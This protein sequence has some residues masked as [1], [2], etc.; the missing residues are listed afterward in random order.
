MDNKEK[1]YK[2]LSE[3]Y[4]LGTFEQFSA[5]L[6][7]EEKRRKL[8]DATS[9]DYDYGDYESFSAQLGYKEPFKMAEPFD[10]N[11]ANEESLA[12]LTAPQQQAYVP[13]PST[14]S[15]Y[16]GQAPVIE[17]APRR[18]FIAG[19]QESWKGLKAGTQF[20]YG[21]VVN[22]IFG[23]SQDDANALYE[24]NEML[25]QGKDVASEVE[26]A[27]TDA[28]RE[29]RTGALEFLPGWAIK[30]LKD[31][32]YKEAEHQKIL[33]DIREVLGET[34]GDV[35]KARQILE[36]RA[37]DLSHGDRVKL[38]A[39][40]QFGNIRE[41]EGFGAW[42]GENT[43][44]MI[45]SASALIVG[46]L[47]K[48]PAAARA[49]GMIGMGGMTAA[50][51][52]SSMYEAREAGASDLET[53]KVGVVD[54]AIEYITEKLPFDN[55]TNWMV[56][57]TKGKVATEVARA[58]RSK[59]SPV[60]AEMEKL[61][62]MANKELGGKLFSK[63][64]A[65]A[66]IAD[67]VAEGASEFTAEASQT[68][69]RLMY[70][71]PD[72]F[73]LLGE[74]LAN[75]WQG[76]LAGF[77]MGGV[78]GGASKTMEHHQNRERRQ[79][80]GYVDVGLVNF[81]TA[82][83]P[84][85]DIVEVISVSEDTDLAQVL[86]DGAI[87]NVNKNA[88][89]Q[90]YRYSYE[91]F[92]AGRMRVLESEALDNESVTQ[93]MIQAADSRE[94]TAQQNL[95]EALRASGMA[96]DEIMT[97]LDD[98]DADKI[99]MFDSPDIENAYN[100]YRDARH[101][102][103]ELR[104][105][106]ARQA[107]SALNLKRL[108]I[109]ENAGQFW[110]DNQTEDAN[111]NPIFNPT[112][113]TG[114]M[115]DGTRVYVL[116]DVNEQGECAA[117]TENGEKKI[118]KAD[119]LQDGTQVFTLDEYLQSLVDADK[120]QQEQTRMV[121]Q[122]QDR[123]TQARQAA[124]PGTQINLGTEEDPVI[125]SVVEQGPDGVIVQSE[126]GASQLT[127]DEYANA[128]HIGAPALTDNETAGVEAA[129]ILSAESAYNNEV[130][131]TESEAKEVADESGAALQEF[132]QADPLPRDAEGNVD[133]T[134]LWNDSPA[135][136]AEWNDEQ[137][138]DGGANSIQ[139]IDAAVAK[140][141]AT[142]A[143]QQAAYGA[144]PVG[145]ERNAVE[146]EIASLQ[147]RLAELLNVQQRY[148]APVAEEVTETAAEAP[149]AEVVEEPA[150]EA[151][152][153]VRE[154][155]TQLYN[156]PELSE[157]E[158][159]AFINAN[160]QE[161]QKALDKHLDKA[162]KMGTDMAKYKADRAK[163][164][165]KTAELE[166]QR[167]FWR[168][169]QSYIEMPDVTEMDMEPQNALEFTANELTR[170]DGV[171]LQR[172][173]FTR[174]TGYGS[175]AGN[176]LSMLRTKQNGGLTLEEAGERLMEMDREN[177]TGFF[178][179]SDPNAGL[180]AI[181]EV[182]GGARTSGDVSGYIKAN[183]EQLAREEMAAARNAMMEEM[184]QPEVEIIDNLE[185]DLPEDIFMR[186]VDE[187]EAIGGAATVKGRAE[188][189]E[190]RLGIKMNVLED[191]SQVKNRAI[192]KAIER[193][194]QA[195]GWFDRATGEVCI[196]APQI[197]NM[198]EVDKTVI[199]E[200][201]SHKGLR[202]LLGEEGFNALCDYVWQ[203]MKPEARAKYLTYE[204]VLKGERKAEY[205][206]NPEAFIPT[207]K[208]SRAAAD[209]FI[210]GYSESI[211]TD[212][213]A[214][215]K[216][217][218]SVKRFINKLTGNYSL[219]D[220]LDELLDA[221]LARYETIAK[222]DLQGVVEEGQ[223]YGGI[224][225][226]ETG[227]KIDA[228][229]DIQAEGN[230]SFRAKDGSLVGMHNISE[231]KL[232]K[233]IKQGGLANPSTAVVNID[234]YSLEG[235][236]EIS[237]IMPSSLV[238]P[239]TGNNAGTYSGDAWTPTYPSISR[240]VDD[241]GWKVIKDRI[242][243]AVGEE[244]ALYSDI[245][246]GVD[247]YLDDN[248]RSKM[249]FVF[250][251]EKGIEPE[252]KYKGAEGLVG[253]RNL[254]AIL[255]V[256]GLR[257]GWESYEKY[258]AASPMS[259]R[260]FNMWV[261]SG[262]DKTAHRELK[263]MLKKEPR[264]A[265][266]L[267]L[268]E[269]LPFAKFDSFTYHI[270]KTERDAGR[271]DTY[272]TM[273][274]A[275]SYVDANNLRAEFEQWL[276]SLM[277][278]A[279]AREVFF[280]GF[281]RDG[282]RIYKDNTLENVSR[283]M[284]MQ[285][286]TN[287]YDDKGLSAT[288]SVLLERFESLSQIRRNRGRLADERT[289]NKA[290]DELKDRLYNIIS[291]LSDMETISS[292]PF[293]NLDY[294]ESRLQDALTKRNPVAYLNKEYGYS[295]DPKG[296][297]ASE[298]KSFI[299][300][301]QKMPAKYFETKFE[302]PVYLN[303][304]AAAVMPA[305]TG[306]DIKQAISEAGLPIYEYDSS[307]EGA[308]HEATLKA[309]DDND[310]RFRII[311]EEG[312][313]NLDAA[314][315]A[316]VRLDNLTA[317]REMEA[318]GKDAKAIKL[319]T[320]WERGT[321]N[322]WR[323]EVPDDFDLT[324]L[325]NR[326]QE[327]LNDGMSKAWGIVYPS[328]LGDLVNE[329]PDFNVDI[330]VWVGDE[331]DNTGEYS[332]AT[333]G[334]E[335][336]FG[337]SASIEVRAKTVA[338]IKS[339]LV[340]EIQ[341]AIQEKEGFAEGGN[342]FG[343][344]D[345][346]SAELDKRVERIK[347]LRAEGRDAEADEL[348]SMSKGL[349]EAV[350]NN[351]DDA[352]GNYRK[353]A[354]E[355]EARNASARLGMTMQERR[356]TLLSETEDVAPEDQ[357]ILMDAV[358]SAGSSLRFRISNENQ[359]IFVS[360][361][362]RAVEGIKQEKATPE[363]WLKMIEKNGGLK[364]GE[365]KWMGL[366]D[367]LKASDKK[368]L[369]K[370]E[371]LDFIN[372]NMI[373]IEEQH[374]SE[375]EN[376]L[377]G[378][379]PEIQE[380][381]Q[382]FFDEYVAES[383]DMNDDMF[384]KTHYDYAIQKLADK[385][386][387]TAFNAPFI[388]N[389]ALVELD[390]Y[391]D[392]LDTLH[393]LNNKLGLEKYDGTRDI[394]DT[395][396]SYTTEGLTD[397]HEIA[398]VVPT[399]ESWNES[400]DIHFGDAGDG[401]A[402]AW[403]RFGDAMKLLGTTEVD[404]KKKFNWAKVLVID[405]IQSK[406]HQEGRE[407]GYRTK[408]DDEL[409]QKRGVAHW[410]MMKKYNVST[411]Y[412]L[413]QVIS[414]EDAQ[415]LESL[416]Q[417][418]KVGEIPDAPFDK[419]WHEL[420][421][422]RMLRYAAENGYDVIAWTKG[423]QQADRYNIG[424]IISEIKSTKYPRGYEVVS[425]GNNG[426]I[427]HNEV[428][429]DESA[430]AGVYG[431]E[432]AKRIIESVDALE[433]SETATISGD[434]LRIGGEGMKGFYDKMLPA[435]MNKY[436]KKWGVKVEDINLPGLANGLTMH[437]VP[438]TEEMKA[439]VM[440]GQVM[441]RVRGENE[442]AMDFHQS[443]VDDFLAKYNPNTEVRVFPVNEETARMFG[444]TLEELKK[445]HGR[446]LPS[447]DFI[448]IFAREDIVEG[449]DVEGTLFH[450]SIHKL[451]QF[452]DYMREAGK[453]MYENSDNNEV[454]AEY[455]KEIIDKNYA[456]YSDEKKHEE[457]LAHALEGAMKYGGT[458]WLLA[459]VPDD[460]KN[461]I[462]EILNEIGYDR[463]RESTERVRRS[464]GESS[465][466]E[467]GTE[468]L[469]GEK[470]PEAGGQSGIQET[471]R[472]IAEGGTGS[473][474]PQS[475]MAEDIQETV[476][477]RESQSG[478]PRQTGADSGSEDVSF[479]VTDITPEVRAEMNTISAIALVNGTY[480]KA[481]NGADT[482]L[483]PEQWALVRTKNFLRWFGDWIN[484]PENASKV[485]DENGE[486]KV[487]YHGSATSGI[488]AFDKSRIRAGETD[489]NYNGFWFS[490]DEDTLPAWVRKEARYDVFL[491][492]VNPISDKE[493]EIISKEVLLSDKDYAGAR[494]LA[495]A[496]RF[497]LQSRG[498]DGVLH[499]TH[500]DIDF[501]KLENDGYV[502]FETSRGAR[503]L[504]ERNPEGVYEIYRY[505]KYEEDHKGAFYGDFD[506]I[507]DIKKDPYFFGEEIYVVFEPSQIKSA[508]DNTGEF[509]EE[510][511][512]IRYRISSDSET[513][514]ESL[515][516]RT[517]R[518]SGAFSFSGKEKIESRDDVAFIF[519]QLED[520]AIE[521][522]F[523]V[524]VKDGI[525]TVIHVGMG[526][527]SY[528]MIDNSVVLPAYKDFGA[529]KIYM[530]HNHPSGSLYAS[531]ADLD[532]LKT[533]SM[534]I[535]DIS[536]EGIIINTV[537]GEY[538]SFDLSSSTQSPIPTDE[539]IVPVKVLSF[540]KNVFAPDYKSKINERK[541]KG[542]DD[543]ASFLSAHRL[544]EGTK[545]GALLLNRQNMINGNLVTND[546]EVSVENADTLASQI[547]EAANRTGSSA[548]ILFGDFDYSD[549]ALRSLS[550]GIKRA[551]GNSISLLDVV[552][553]EGNHT[554]SLADETLSSRSTLGDGIRFRTSEEAQEL[555]N[556][557]QDNAETLAP[558]QLTEDIWKEEIEGK[559]FS[560]P[561][562]IVRLGHNQFDKNINKGRAREFGMLIPTI[563]RPDLIFEESAPEEGAERQTK[564]VFV[565]TFIDESGAK[566]INYASISV[567]KEGMEVVESSHRLRD[568]QVLNKIEKEQ[569]LWNRFASDS[570][571]SAPGISTDQSN[572]LSDNKDSDNLDKSNDLDENI[573]YRIT[574]TPT[575]QV[576]AEGVSLSP[577]DMARVAGRIFSVLP[578]EA[579]REVTASLNG[580]I[581]GL[582]DAIMQ[583][584]ARL[585][586]KQDWDEQ[587][588]AVAE[589][590]AAEMDRI[591]PDK[592]RPFSTYEGLWMLYDALTPA[593]SLNLMDQAS[594]A[595][596]KRNLGVDEATLERMKGYD[597]DVRFRT[598]GDATINAEASLYNKG[599]S[600]VWT[601]LKE[602]FVDM[603]ASVEKLVKAIEKK[604]GMKAQGFEN[605]LNALNQ[606]SSKGLA[607]MKGYTRTYLKP[608]FKAIREIMDNTDFKYEDIVRYVILKHGLERNRKLA[609]RDAR[610][611][612]QEIY[613]DII[614]KIKG[615]SDA[616]K[617]TYLTN[618]QLRDADAK[619][620]LAGLQNV[621]TSILTD[622]QKREHKR[623]LAKARKAV[624][625]AAEY[626]E[627]AK[628]I[629]SLSEQE[630]Q[631]EL[632]KIFENIEN[633]TDSV[634][635]EL[636]KN[637]YS[638]ISSMFY[639]QLGVNRKDYSTEEQY[640]SALMLAKND[641]Y[642]TLADVEAAAEAEVKTF[643][644]TVSTKELWKRINAATKETLRQQYEANMISRD[645]YES[646]RNMFEY[647]V[648]LRGFKDNTAEDMYTYYR[649]PNSTGYTKPILGAEGRKTEAESPFGWIAAMAGSAVASN[650]KNQAKLA[651]YYFVSNRPENGIATLS[652]T[653]FVDS[654][655]VDADGRKV[656]KP[657][658]PPFTED[659][660]SDAA[661]ASY[662]AWQENMR[663]LQKKGQAY[664]S[665]QRLNL[666]NAV[667]NIS[668]ANK[669]E[670]IVNVKVAGKDYTILINGNPRAAQAINGQLNIEA[671]AQDYTALFGPV[672][673]WMSSVNT[674]YNPEFWITNMMRDMLFT[675]M[676][677]NTK[678]DAAYRRKF[679]KNYLKA[680]KVVKMVHQNEKGT[681][682]DSY[683]EDM[684]KEFEKNGGVTGYTQIKG[685]EEWEKEIAKQ[686][687]SEDPEGKKA[688]K[689]MRK[690]MDGF[691]W[692]HRTGE[693]L[694]QVSRFAAFLT[695]R[696][697]GKPMSE[698]I[699]DAKEIT[700]NFNRKGSGKRITFE[701]ARYLTDKNGQPLNAFQQWLA[702]GL[703]SIAP[704]GRRTIMFFNAAM[705]GL[706]ATAKLIKKNPQ[707]MAAWSL[708]YFAIGVMNAVLHNM[709]D[710]DDDYLDMPEYERRNALMLGGNGVYFKW[711][712]PQEM[713]MI[714]GLGDLAV[715]AILGRNP[716]ESTLAEAV[717][718]VTEVLPINP[719]E[720]WRAFL[721]S[722]AIPFVELGV[723]E[724]YKGDPIYNEQKWLSEG[725][726][727]R[728]AKW[729][730]A[731]KSTGRV[732]IEIAKAL[733]SIT[734]GDEYD[735]GRINLQP[736]KL[737]YL[738][739]SA[740]G[741]TVRTA[742]KFVSSVI[743]AIDPEED[744]AIR[745]VPFLNRVLTLNDERYK[746]VHVNDVFEWYENEV[747]HAIS[748]E[749]KFKRDKQTGK[750]EELKASDEYKWIAVYKKYEKDLKLKKAQLKAAPD[751][752]TRMEL[753]K[754][755]DEIKKRVIK[756]ISAMQ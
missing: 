332:P 352:Y 291:Q 372:E 374:Y 710:D 148:V 574:G 134:T 666:G 159:E 297:Y 305:T 665:G 441:F 571:S 521:N 497:E 565:K 25:R 157:S 413:R 90:Q 405:E 265:D 136:W 663:E 439:S 642:S 418:K 615:L 714:Y 522:S 624:E 479:R 755:Q 690:V 266:V 198:S 337:R 746:N 618:A 329:Y 404:G 573:S 557:M 156:D 500:P 533:I 330:M 227:A 219:V 481:P 216:M 722:V 259:K 664:E 695:A 296:E 731:Y 514:I 704:L 545:V 544:G 317:A 547:A 315:E 673:R 551:S 40:R 319:A 357:I 628:K 471:N 652:R 236:G 287:A 174:H 502:E 444:Y 342:A 542:S 518:T 494:S 523:L 111:G 488:T 530:V 207:E 346:L 8:Y 281:T 508:T 656:F 650:V 12:G 495:D 345:K 613:D 425:F 69:T 340:H 92:E 248:H 349:A 558:R 734:G 543:V 661:K 37:M 34:N 397:K 717:K 491:K 18:G 527:T 442:S 562:G 167:D 271:V 161:S 338:D 598:V 39:Q 406:R 430:M 376:A 456:A 640:Q 129:E 87:I 85:N 127:W 334:D 5:D 454:F 462:N 420:A 541:I 400:D 391:E 72:L 61:L 293:I 706:N 20:A 368:T 445:R 438:V 593:S 432:M 568:K 639:D 484:D 38:D 162:P 616:Q 26:G 475:E 114:L 678:E 468:S 711:A 168:E 116:S 387:Y 415:Y 81:G 549:R 745:Q 298:L 4:D 149:A 103:R 304:F 177:G 361:A 249:E 381:L 749:K 609:Q 744:V 741:G 423:E 31:R 713:R 261:D 505:S 379:R 152:N 238:D 128:M 71:N 412:E 52:G 365:D 213:N 556:F 176:F 427:V 667:V 83:N 537:S 702:V 208:E 538:A 580:N 106:S 564:Y 88:I 476:R 143:E 170:K 138:Q 752:R 21:E 178:D 299:K 294:A 354:G 126:A 118:I 245:V 519:K 612:Y 431:K 653:W 411:P 155:L 375:D 183:R 668:D 137:R 131:Q 712:L 520:S 91:A 123:M 273:A 65:A 22:G 719:T 256:E 13:S 220:Q 70:D 212:K 708:A 555:L 355:V 512:D 572:A 386:G 175:E 600:N 707:K 637:D 447:Y 206:A 66:Y 646:L 231:D 182:I 638:G 440:E 504:I 694:E 263:E 632:D 250:L 351:E 283:H 567:Q 477:G 402:V 608:M 449:E 122:T 698:A 94:A 151:A 493:A 701:E 589:A 60:R 605:I 751:T 233:A 579:R 15:Q 321:D 677:V 28:G 320:G 255:G 80:Q 644:G 480:L 416:Y 194:L 10:M 153:P 192:R 507:E 307:V 601:R 611:H 683:L 2:A 17:Q 150:V 30:G 23:S 738:V 163:H 607:A 396:L 270:W 629:A 517:F 43:V 419:N 47:T 33:D 448:A 110:R 384:M 740:F 29:I 204:G 41:T 292:N 641:R 224:I 429:A 24:L 9:D 104:R 343:L 32:V 697:M 720:G 693:S 285:G 469:T 561:I 336:T 685:S 274:A 489:A 260:S 648:P 422:K 229:S 185:E 222:M 217:I 724:D 687:A 703:S 160:V 96:D 452:F 465:I 57:K 584:P 750:L 532:S 682:G 142:I 482:N 312:A 181:L 173:S 735:A 327:N 367:W 262:G 619:A 133:E 226:A 383:E 436:G 620:E 95:V 247:N 443:M 531:K 366:S 382:G 606:Q 358:E 191:V 252:I 649:K 221:S 622:E 268:N 478:G 576:V 284:R 409:V 726:K 301:V 728:T 107:Q 73:P 202:G 117:V 459:N 344:K 3:E 578:E 651:L 377:D 385:L 700:V 588:M 636:R 147:E 295:I 582:Q 42:L 310:V 428:F 172:D 115:Q 674:S 235:Y 49:I 635:Q 410:E 552:R 597:D 130:A 210:A 97:L 546:N 390:F 132:E 395:R 727:E 680:F 280:A 602:S 16:E 506:T 169:V 535:P 218:D 125:G 634:Y 526:G 82:E 201:I 154:T 614:T 203:N 670:H 499:Q 27:W 324:E 733:N 599:A 86:R 146:Q 671:S 373:I 272:D 253:I 232:R 56:G 243:A 560:S 369:T 617:R 407:K 309:T 196:Y 348:M 585:A 186:T 587:D 457:M 577:A 135:R 654:G 705:Q 64:N 269:D 7:N 570:T 102:A 108:S 120:V 51:S 466:G 392:D 643:E 145:K 339:V 237:L 364:A 264:L 524:F 437:S 688:G 184:I 554:L 300:D 498:Y 141:S 11:K 509:S 511:G 575:E 14:D 257:Y 426:N 433:P 166:K 318:A 165:A 140:L 515:V 434:N 753:T 659:L 279:G 180:N 325:E 490:T 124:Q 586:M 496:T 93:G 311:G 548:V 378:K 112:V 36:E 242:R 675:F 540:D 371:V 78:L 681:I 569:M 501:V 725:E 721:P 63:K 699:D 625:E 360:N 350:I 594:R 435:F 347:E 200:V 322:L 718:I 458:E 333:E 76:A 199:H 716:H 539:G 451:A 393:E 225:D 244:P 655:E 98:A 621:N 205:S 77:F 513:G 101:R 610:A 676:S 686:L 662:E 403:I 267:K 119:M 139:A 331:F 121:E 550:K 487:V 277:E 44:Q 747:L 553:L 631:D 54:G 660:S 709:F 306:E 563:E 595:I 463:E 516:E 754:A 215:Q 446:Y 748:L 460:S 421:M 470:G 370:A 209:E 473:G 483:T 55:Y 68:M 48:S 455:R 414:S 464:A 529:D 723:N 679:A 230:V 251:K 492:L 401:R 362:A 79:K 739:Q 730:S 275:S 581:L 696:E 623:D 164:Q 657:A 503:Y 144:M 158:I 67:M 282:D 380:A 604:T 335:N 566:H 756:E 424:G 647:Y 46:A 99:R 195:P 715:E 630:A 179:Q 467:S 109:E 171:K 474:I 627:R 633:G 626:L 241:R 591:T 100:I 510:D 105:T 450:E 19:A 308:R 485:V 75:G 689:M 187:T 316:S 1:L 189:W 328:D 669:P 314:E 326:L 53:H 732:Y 188:A 359:A 35:A 363:Q 389:N 197:P 240:K 58:L 303:E 590:I 583:I 246:L 190:K 89:G 461:I 736:E 356:E 525:P 394:N 341:H 398:L 59:N 211:N 388:N 276:E 289:Y 743:N 399:I 408:E 672:L 353:L 603:N 592:T 254:E 453:W 223:T 534:Q 486:P 559:T 742:D 692:F 288:K 74:A 417:G 6:D 528:T 729:S 45:P 737:E 286:R 596:V 323:Y 313:A 290:Y 645:Q 239:E 536:V 691:S 258:K 193:G 472:E 658:Y 228:S 684:Y 84:D 214:W 302:R 62:T 278:Q 234:E 113:E 50:T